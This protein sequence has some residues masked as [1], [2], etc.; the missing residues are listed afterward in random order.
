MRSSI[1][2]WQSPEI[3]ELVAVTAVRRRSVRPPDFGSETR[4]SDGYWLI[5]KVMMRSTLVRPLIGSATIRL[6]VSAP[7]MCGCLMDACRM[8][9]VEI[10]SMVRHT[11]V[12]LACWNCCTGVGRLMG[13]TGVVG[14]GASGLR[15]YLEGSVCSRNLESNWGHTV[16]P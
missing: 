1:D 10:V 5:A 13:S 6:D 9:S 14:G 11:P 7:G 15:I 16:Q 12:R 4:F 2:W 8:H 3:A